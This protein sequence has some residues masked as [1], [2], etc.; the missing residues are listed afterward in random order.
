MANDPHILIVDDEED[1]LMLCRVNLEFEGFEVSEAPNGA[2]AVELARSLK[3]DVILLDVMMPVKDGWETL[4]ELKSDPALSSIPVVMLT[5]KVQEEDQYR[6]LS[7]G[8][9]D[10]VTKPFHPTALIQTMRN[11]AS[12]DSAELEQRRKDALRK[13]DMFRKL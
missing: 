11:I 10:Y 12:T 5:A 6:A 7:A 1:V 4:N 9:A 13:L 2:V 8:A 3:P